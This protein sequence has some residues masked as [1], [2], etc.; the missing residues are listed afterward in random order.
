[1]FFWQHSVEASKHDRIGAYIDWA[2]VK[3]ME[4]DRNREVAE[5]RLWARVA[6][7][8]PDNS[9]PGFVVLRRASRHFTPSHKSPYPPAKPP[10]HSWFVPQPPHFSP[11]NPEHTIR[12]GWVRAFS[13]PPGNARFVQFILKT[14]IPNLI[15]PN[16][17]CYFEL[18]K[19]GEKINRVIHLS[20][21]SNQRGNYQERGK[22]ISKPILLM[23]AIYFFVLHRILRVRQGT[24]NERKFHLRYLSLLLYKLTP[25]MYIDIYPSWEN[26]QCELAPDLSLVDALCDIENKVRQTRYS[27]KWRWQEWY[28]EI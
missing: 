21:G 22:L 15:D 3:W 1:M 12:T 23:N 26:P 18:K 10:L 17:H 11:N 16:S 8:S 14:R 2:R 9:W 4:G 6:R 25:E 5:C 20:R 28:S 24:L 19:H 13:I 7:V 27:V